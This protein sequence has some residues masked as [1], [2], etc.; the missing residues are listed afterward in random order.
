MYIFKSRLYIA[1]I[2]ISESKDELKMIQ[3]EIE[4]EHHNRTLGNRKHFTIHVIVVT[5]AKEKMWQRNYIRR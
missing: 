1:K 3:R 4:K 2:E 5:K